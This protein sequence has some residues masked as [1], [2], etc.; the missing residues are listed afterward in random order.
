MLN[1]FVVEGRLTKDAVITEVGEKNTVTK[2]DIACDRDYVKPGEERQTDFFKVVAWNQSQKFIERFLKKGELVIVHGSCQ[3][4]K[5]TDKDGNVR[6]VTEI[7]ADKI[8]PTNFKN[9]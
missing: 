5:W 8:Y 6:Y 2:F 3:T 4:R 7:I 1:V 9:D